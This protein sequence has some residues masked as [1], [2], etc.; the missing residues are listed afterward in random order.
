MGTLRE[1]SGREIV[2]A[3]EALVAAAQPAGQVVAFSRPCLSL[4]VR[5]SPEA[6]LAAR[7]RGER[8][9][10]VRRS[11]GGTGVLTGPG[12]LAWSL[13]LPVE[14]PLVGRDFVR[15]YDRLGRAVVHALRSQGVPAAWSSPPAL[16]EELC[17][18][19]SRGRVL[20]S[21]GKILGGAAQRR[22]GRALL[23][24]GYLARRI[25]LDRVARIFELPA[26]LLRE[27]L[28]GWEDVG[29]T[30]T[31][32]ELAGL[33]TSELE[34]EIGAPPAAGGPPP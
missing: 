3:D 8:I 34:R 23:H 22:T 13:V 31:P 9:D 2:A 10:V 1:G 26:S 17:V 32:A 16:S 27:H 15:A 33:V 25:D 29:P 7:A 14:H 5:Q 12:D 28:A 20:T 11:T 6:A 18:L 30:L 21:G 24:H 4:G 19:G